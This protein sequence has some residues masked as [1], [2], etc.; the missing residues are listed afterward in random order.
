MPADEGRRIRQE[1]AEFFNNRKSAQGYR[2]CEALNF[3][4]HNKARIKIYQKTKIKKLINCSLLA[5]VSSSVPASQEYFGRAQGRADEFL[6]NWLWTERSA[7]MKVGGRSRIVIGKWNAGI[8]PHSLAGMRN[9]DCV[10]RSMKPGG[11]L[12]LTR[13]LRAKGETTL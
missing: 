7:L 4:N 13:E 5:F 2:G 3:Q 11:I 6:R 12:K 8:S 10:L 9:A 1:A